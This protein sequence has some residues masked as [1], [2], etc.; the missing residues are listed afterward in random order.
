[1]YTIMIA[2]PFIYARFNLLLF[3]SQNRESSYL[4]QKSPYSVYT[5]YILRILFFS[6]LLT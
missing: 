4:S 3:F 1:M 2:K 6:G 5:L